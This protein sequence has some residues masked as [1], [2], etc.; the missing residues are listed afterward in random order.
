MASY[1]SN[2]IIILD[3][4]NSVGVGTGGSLTVGGG[5]SVGQDTYIGGGI[6]VS[7]TSASFADNIIVVNSTPTSSVD[8]GFLFGRYSGD[9]TS[10]NNYSAIIYSEVN[11]NFN[12]GYAI[13]DTRGTEL[14]NAYLPLVVGGLTIT[15]GSLIALGNNTISNLFSNNISS[16]N[17]NITNAIHTNFTSTNVV[18][19]NGTITNI[20]HTNI[21]S[22]SLSVSVGITTGTLLATTSIST[23]NVYAPSSTFINTFSTNLTANNLLTIFGITTGTLLATYNVSTGTINAAAGTITNATFTNITSSTLNTTGITTANLLATTNVSSA[24]ISGV[25][26]TITN[27]VHTNITSSSLNVTGI[28]TSTVLA[29]SNISTGSLS[30]Q[31]GTLINLSSTNA[32]TS[33]LNVANVTASSILATT[34]ISSGSILGT[35]ST[36]TN[37][38]SSTMS[39]DTLILSTGVTTPSLLAPT[40][41]SSIGSFVNLTTGN[42]YV[43][44]NITA[45]GLV[46]TNIQGTNMTATNNVLSNITSNNVFVSGGITSGTIKS[47]IG[48]FSTLGSS[49]LN[50]TT[51]SAGAISLSGNLYVGGTL[52]TVNVTTLNLSDTNLT[53]GFVVVTASLAAIGNSNTIGTIFTTAGNIGINTTAPAY[54][55]DINGV[56]RITNYLTTGNVFA[57]G[58]TINNL[59]LTN[60]STGS[61]ALTNLLSTNSSITNSIIN[62]LTSPTSVITNLTSTNIISTNITSGGVYVISANPPKVQ[63]DVQHSQ[64]NE[65]QLVFLNSGGTGDFRI[66]GDGGDIQWL[67]G[68]SRALQMGAYHEVI[69]LGG[70]T[71]TATIPQANGNNSTYNT[72]IINTNNS[73]A[74]VIQGN[75][76]GTQTNN[77]TE[78][79]NS[80]GSI[81]TTVNSFGDIAV[82]ST[83]ASLGITTG[84]IQ[85]Y[86]GVGIVGSLN[87]GG[88]FNC[89]NA[90]I[91][92]LLVTATTFNNIIANS[93]T[94]GNLYVTSGNVYNNGYLLHGRD[95]YSASSTGAS[96][97]A[98]TTAATK[99]NITTGTLSAGTYAIYGSYAVSTNTN[100]KTWQLNITVDGSIIISNLASTGSSGTDIPFNTLSALVPLTSGTHGISLTYQ[101]VQSQ[102]I[103]ISKAT[104][105]LY[106]IA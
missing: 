25:N 106:R 95:F 35:N 104:L 15:G 72:R 38:V 60:L 28:T 49:W 76:N 41:N 45:G 93:I 52:T 58:G 80:G 7:G 39:S 27:I 43:N 83:T 97:S 19:T 30:A 92:N 33:T 16:A 94:S 21:S 65:G 51:M 47:I 87:V 32:T 105:W 6:A 96:S 55:L 31:S 23:A 62:N 48:N 24:N 37:V 64:V 1:E 14:I 100:N 9:I 2:P 53:A 77:L 59:V 57:A 5:I 99:I 3:T 46:S 91:Q 71:A 34:S 63:I 26:S 66:Y 61:I 22:S 20:I 54:T 81:L 44:T 79:W 8:T 69:L 98:S 86:G 67:G 50:A 89:Q 85:T 10:N 29:T 36:I 84:S 101:V 102:T 11:K 82:N 42:I 4:T 103:N 56:T 74:L 13:G 75:I 78:W 68:G 90:T 40:I 88:G 18:S 17:A 70:R 12:F 73:K